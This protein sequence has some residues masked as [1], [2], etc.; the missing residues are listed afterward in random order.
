VIGRL[1]F[2]ARLRAHRERQGIPLRSIAESTKI[3]YSLLEA[4]ERGNVSQWP[5]GL[6]RRAYLRDYAAAVHLPAEPLVAE[7]LQLFP[8]DGAD[9]PRDT[10]PSPLRLTLD[11]PPMA[12]RAARRGAGAALEVGAVAAVAGLVWWSTSMPYMESFGILALVY[13]PLAMVLVD[14]TGVLRQLKALVTPGSL[15]TAAATQTASLE[16]ARLYVV[17][18]ERPGQAFTA[19][20]G[21]DD[22]AQSQTASR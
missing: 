19:A 2:G 20:V 10:T 21:D 18:R 9:A 13:Y 16:P 17:G 3:Q 11:A 4:L 15:A 14:R 12:L 5:Q 6:F 1:G 8:E 7:F 22:M